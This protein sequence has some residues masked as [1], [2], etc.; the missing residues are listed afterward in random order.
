[1]ADIQSNINVNINTSE[2]L[3]NVRTLQ[4]QI[5]AFYESMA[6]SGAAASAAASNMQSNLI[7]T[8]NQTGKF[9]A[10]IKTIA[11]T[12]E[13]F[14]TALEKNKLS[15]GQ[16]FKFAGGASKT[17]GKFFKT[18]M[19][20]I[21]KVAR[22]R[23]KTLQTQYVRLGRDASGALKSI[24]IRPLSLDMQDLGTKTAIAA[25]KQQLMNQLLKQGSTNLL[26]FGKN[27]Q[28]AGR[29]LMVGFTIPLSMVGTA[30]AKTF[31]AMEQQVIKFRR[32]YGDSMTPT[33]ETDAMID[34]IRDLATEFTKY[35]VAA[36][37][38]MELAAT[39]AAA[40]N[41]GADLT[42]QVREANRLAVLGQVEQQE[43]LTTTIS[44]TNAFGIAASDLAKKIDFL[45]AVENQTV[46]SI[47]D[48]TIAVP[49]AGPVVKQLGGDVEDLAFFLTAMKEGGINASEGA[50]ALKSGLAALIN[51]TGKA[52]EMLAGFGI[53]IKEIVE[54]NRGDVKGLVIDFASALD[55]LDPLSR[56]RAIEQL[57][58]KFQF[59][60]LSTLFQ[61]VIADGTQASRVLEL[62]GRSASD[63][64]ALSSK[65]LGTVAASSMFKFQ[66][67]VEE[68]KVALAP[69]GEIFLKLVTPV[70]EF[71]AKILENFNKLD[72]GAKNLIMGLIAVVG[73]LGPV[74]IMTFGLLANGVANI[75]KGFMLVKRIFGQSGD[76]SRY[77]GDQTEYMT[78]QQLEATSVA[79]SLEQVHQRLEQRFTSEAVAVDKLTQALQRANNA[80][81]TFQGR[82]AGQVTMP[83]KYAKGVVS[84]PG[85]KGA[86]DI[87]PAMLAPGEAVVP[88][89]QATKYAAL[90]QGIVADNIPGFEDG[91]VVPRK[92]RTD[93]VG[94]GTEGRKDKSFATVQRPYGANVSAQAGL[95]DLVDI[96]PSDLADLS[97]IYIKQIRE[98]AGVS[99]AAIN[100]EI[101]QWEAENVDA[102]KL[103][104][105]QVNAGVDPTTA[106]KDLTEKFNADMKA[107]NGAVAKMS[108]TFEKMVPELQADLKEAQQYVEKY[109]LNIKDSA[110]DAQKLA[111]ALPNNQLAQMAATPGNFQSAARQRQAL[112][113]IQGGTSGIA[114][115]GVARFMVQKGQPQNSPANL[116]AASQEHFSTTLQQMEQR[117]L[118]KLKRIEIRSQ[119]SVR[120]IT[121]KAAKSV[122]TMVT[123]VITETRNAVSQGLNVAI[124]R[125]SPPKEAIRIGKDYGFA[126]NGALREMI[127]QTK[128]AGQAF[129]LAATTG[130]TTVTPAMSQHL[131]DVAGRIVRPY[132]DAQGTL[133][134][135]MKQ[136]VQILEKE[137][138]AARAAAVAQNAN[139]LAM[140]QT[141]T[142]GFI[143]PLQQSL[144][145]DRPGKKQKGRQ[146]APDADGNTS[147]LN[148][149]MNAIRSTSFALTSLAAAGTMAGGSIGQA[150]TAIMQFSGV[151]YA[152]ITVMDLLSMASGRAKA[153]ILA[154]I[155]SFLM[156][157]KGRAGGVGFLASLKNAITPLSAAF[158]AGG[159]GFKGF[160]NVVKTAGLN[161]G[162]FVLA[163]GR[164]VPV[165]G[166][167]ATGL[168]VLGFIVK[169][170]ID[171]KEKERLATE[172]VSDAMINTK[173]ELDAVANALGK[174]RVVS[175]IERVGVGGTGQAA[176]A[177]VST[178]ETLRSDQSF[179]D[180]YKKDIDAMRTMSQRE[181]KLYQ[182]TLAIRLQAEGQ[183]TQEEIQGVITAL[184]QEAGKTAVKLDFASI[185]ITSKDPKQ[186]QKV[187]DRFAASAKDSQSG[188][189][190]Q[191]QATEAMNIATS[192]YYET[193]MA[194]STALT[195]GAVNLEQYNS[196]V[197]TL[198]SSLD[199]LGEV[200][201]TK[202][203][204]GMLEDFVEALPES[205][206]ELG[207]LAGSV[208]G[209]N[210]QLFIM[211]ALTSGSIATITELKEVIKALN[212]VAA[213]VGSGVTQAQ[214]DAAK[215]TIDR[216]TAS[217]T[218]LN[219]ETAK[220]NDQIT[221]GTTGGE[222]SVFQKAVED[223]QGNITSI[224]EASKA[225]N[226][227]SKAGFSAA[228]AFTLAQNP[229][230]ATALATTKVGTDKWKQ[231]VQLAKEFISITK[232]KTLS[233][234]LAN[235][236]GEAVRLTKFDKLSKY[237]SQMGLS[238]E[239]ISNVLQDEALADSLIDATEK[240]KKGFQDIDKFVSSKLANIE[241]RIKIFPEEY[242]KQGIQKAMD[243][244]NAKE[245][246]LN[247][248]FRIKTKADQDLIRETQAVISGLNFQADDYEAGL[249]RLEDGEAAIN[250]KY[251]NRLEALDKIIAAND[252]IADQNKEELNI[253]Q[254]VS[255]GDIAGAAAGIAQLQQQ[256]AKNALEAKKESLQAQRTNELESLTVEVMVNNQKV[257]MTRNQ[258][259]ENLKSIKEQI[260]NIEE[261]TL[262]PAQNRVDL[263]Q[264]ELD[265]QTA[266]QTILGKTKDEWELI[267]G[268]IDVAKTSTTTYIAELQRA[269]NVAKDLQ[270]VL[271][272]GGPVV[273]PEDFP[274]K[275]KE[276]PKAK[277][278][279]GG[280]PTPGSLP[281]DD[282][283]LPGSGT[284]K[285][286]AIPSTP[287][288]SSP[289]GDT[290]AP[291]AGMTEFNPLK[292]MQVLA[293]NSERSAIIPKGRY[294]KMPY[295]NYYLGG[296]VQG[297]GDL[298]I[299]YGT[300]PNQ[301]NK[302]MSGSLQ[303]NETGL[304]GRQVIDSWRT[305]ASGGM[306]MPRHLA[307]GGLARGTDIVPA[308]LTPGEFVVSKY[309][310][311][312]YGVD[313]LKAINNGTAGAN[314]VYNGYNINVNV[315]SNSNP[316][317]IANAVMTQIRQINAQQ[318]RGSKF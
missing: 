67:A 128:V 96:D 151:S 264:Q 305:F 229:A 303:K 295:G 142:M 124:Q 243:A 48:L 14:T 11:S 293:N 283:K 206:K 43:A 274:G 195:T 235:L 70:I 7:N 241:L 77:L 53:N 200:A 232:G 309:G 145:S 90:I 99:T 66:K 108:D 239:E 148:K 140:Q 253:F 205:Q 10:S 276:D 284:T 185:D 104:T 60:R 45:N 178:A 162:R 20:T 97:S 301:I 208:E 279:L 196:R 225:Y 55:T 304:D 50:N 219:T 285:T 245:N 147:R 6:R 3:A 180:E 91:N 265:R 29:Q 191:T 176:T 226:L 109:K 173:G 252:R 101:K 236:S 216:V 144:L 84:V 95:V 39:A 102:I 75:I 139:L 312:N 107:N 266:S 83:K 123:S 81:L 207:K 313:N 318:V 278:G 68:L 182:D 209:S 94:S 80:N 220:Y 198:R 257:R 18:E 74:L 47:E 254:M 259:E 157:S 267:G 22:E 44:I 210:N 237:L 161:I 73:G 164:F 307:A 121:K 298:I 127:P 212:I 12:T 184:Q 244:F 35:G 16:Y 223:L 294:F 202:I 143:G 153:G 57:F 296:A 4:R 282:S 23:V 197:A 289:F 214:Y 163:A 242:V 32:V 155:G 201:K 61:N 87:V 117:A 177:A 217:T 168:T 93:R 228:D 234:T 129:G 41:Q 262:E 203:V 33:A 156:F 160:I 136:R 130:M 171:A 113:A 277:S 116:L 86:G 231:L 59:S 258:I 76:S 286:F 38:T 126:L 291:G 132:L 192:G 179:L 106:F 188:N 19:D 27:T 159:K 297:N 222:K 227:L 271:A 119:A 72:A 152:L 24:A 17:F 30:A 317:Q 36:E 218:K 186:F 58:G 149:T 193:L 85:P 316:D 40:G 189:L 288:G 100:R 175:A 8:I 249:T 42:A 269:L 122:E 131:R 88:A 290:F 204:N 114:T 103:A 82:N 238:S 37:K 112:T 275:K 169:A 263:A 314:S 187:V 224:K 64:A 306:V 46:T 165:I 300:K 272:G 308:M 255:R 120:G 21:D 92:R 287:Q 251:D 137:A 273:K 158:V 69:I 63:L 1:M 281:T 211:E 118:N 315:K 65:E 247:L 141:A 135:I 125:N 31:M 133:V 199:S 13:S 105:E 194:T 292:P 2:A 154:Q 270:A 268:N 146:Q 110:E 221:A 9:S 26:N 138:I 170:V 233:D 167:I 54:S 34:Q 28:W 52:S 215:A 310:V 98:Q 134:P 250:E 111:N 56:A 299:R 174:Q 213:G 115:K 261:D 302:K 260:F 248:E 181:I 183:Y 25:Q 256:K 150:S 166:W 5:S 190:N 71:G 172:G 246:V 49:K 280:K 311:Q 240:G 230:L 78:Q 79:A 89:K 15:M 62:T 51:P